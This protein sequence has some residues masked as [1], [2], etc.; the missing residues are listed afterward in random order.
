MINK[1]EKNSNIHSS[2]SHHDRRNYDNWSESRDYNPRRE[3][4]HDWEMERKDRPAFKRP[5]ED[6]FSSSSSS[7]RDS[8]TRKNWQKPEVR[9]RLKEKSESTKEIPPSRE[10]RDSGRE[11][12]METKNCEEDD[13]IPTE[14]ELNKLGAK[15][16]K[17]EIMGNDVS[18]IF[19]Y[20]NI[21]NYV[22][23]NKSGVLV[24]NEKSRNF[25]F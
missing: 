6:N 17:A 25:F 5:R 21:S 19:C 8:N 12:S 23:I 11:T 16:V 22:F 7:W 9:E 4:P 1:A 13:D 24:L 15:I 3:K 20:N 2:K 18:N 10:V 14:E